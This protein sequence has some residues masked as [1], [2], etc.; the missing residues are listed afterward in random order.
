MNIDKQ[1]NGLIARLIVVRYVLN[2]CNSQT[3]EDIKHVV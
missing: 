3:I 1:F 2:I